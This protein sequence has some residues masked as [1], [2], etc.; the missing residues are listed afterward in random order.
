MKKQ[1]SFIVHRARLW[2]ENPWPFAT[3]VGAALLYV[4]A[5]ASGLAEDVLDNDSIVLADG[6]LVHWLA[7]HR[8]PARIGVFDAA[9]SLGNWQVVVVVL[10]AV[11]VFLW[12]RRRR[13]ALAMIVAATG[14]QIV[15][16][17]GK[18][19][20]GRPRPPAVLAVVTPLDA[21]FPSGHASISVALYALGFYLLFRSA[22]SP[23]LK[24]LWLTLAFLFP[25][26]IGFSRLYLGAHYLSDVLAG[27]GVGL[28]WSIFAVG[29]FGFARRRRDAKRQAADFRSRPNTAK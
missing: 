20:F 16:S 13:S 12:N 22:R 28:W 29:V 4:A 14:S 17:L 23:R 3:L 10:I 8:T 27:W 26:L 18:A 9:S 15:V 11:F 1:A 24:R 2:L 7:A 5:L 21:S 25:L 6:W 19:G